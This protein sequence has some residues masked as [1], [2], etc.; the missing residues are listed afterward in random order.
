MRLL[1]TG[2]NGFIGKN[3]CA[4]AARAGHFVYALG[5]RRE[6]ASKCDEYLQCD[7]GDPA[8][9]NS[10]LQAKQ[11]DCCIHLAWIGIPDYSYENS[12]NS[13]RNSFNL[14]EEGYR[15]GIKHFIFTGSCFEYLDPKGAIPEEWP[16]RNTDAFTA[17]KTGLLGMARQYCLERQLDFHWVRP[18]YVIGPNQ[19]ANSVI[20]YVVKC[21]KNGQKPALRTA[22]NENDFIDV[23]DLSKA[24]LRV[25][26][27]DPEQQILNI[28]SGRATPIWSVA[29]EAM[30]AFGLEEEPC[31]Q[32]HEDRI[33]FCA[34]ITKIRQATGWEPQIEL[35]RSIRDYID[36]VQTDR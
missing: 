15:A 6:P 33:S 17:A 20:P 24:I 11:I 30:R 7:L 27:C 19:R 36:S 31:F 8:R 12:W 10:V 18:F 22:Y 28:G 32:H 21:L 3:V 4:D 5:S 16:I 29:G 26:E 35:A 13:V 25:A 2:A 14:L 23:R 9:L 1:I 34:D